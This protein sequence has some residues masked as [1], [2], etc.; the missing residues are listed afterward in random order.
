M[1][2]ALL[3]LAGLYFA[4]PAR[5]DVYS[6]EIDGVIHIT[7]DKPRRGRVLFHLKDGPPR[8]GSAA[9]AGGSP[10]VSR[11]ADAVRH[12]PAEFADT[13]RRAAAYYSLPEALIWAVM[14][15]ESAFNPQAVSDKGAQG[16]LQLMPGTA[17]EMGVSDPFDP[18]Q[19]I[20]G[21]ARY[22]RLLAN[23]FDGD[24]VLA[25]SAYNAGGGAVDNVGGIPYSE[26]AEYVRQVLNYYYAY[27]RTP[28]VTDA[29]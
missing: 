16:L 11:R 28:P 6:T 21:G 10:R 17:E 25:L 27:Q 22:L 13:V 29:P 23:K 20:F 15:V 1:R 18:E 12:V 19:N 2:S 3:V 7:S 9:A 24:L 26:T 8:S 4:V 14:H 5:A